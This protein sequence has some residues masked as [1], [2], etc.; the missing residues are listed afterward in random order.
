MSAFFHIVPSATPLVARAIRAL[1]FAFCAALVT[2]C[3]SGGGGSSSGGGGSGGSAAVAPVIVAQPSPQS[4][5]DSQSAS[6]SVTA[7]GSAP[8]TYQWQRSG[9]AIAGATSA[10]Y[11]IPVAQL[12]DNGASF[13]VTVS[14]PAGSAQSAPATLAVTPVAPSL[15]NNVPTTV[16]VVLGQTATFAV[17]ASGSLPLTFQWR[18]GG[19]PIAGANSSGYTTPA[20]T[21]SD[22]G[23]VFD[24]VV[25]NVAGS[26]TSAPFTLNVTPAPTAVAITTQPLSQTIAVGDPVTFTVTASGTGPITYQW[27]RDGTAIAGAQA[28][29]YT[30]PSTA[31]SDSGRQFSV[32]AVNP[33]GFATSTPALLTVTSR[34]SVA[35][36]AGDIGGPGDRDGTGRAA[37]FNAPAGLAVDNAGNLYVGD[38]GN[39]LLRKVAPTGVVTTVAGS[40]GVAGSTDGLGGA[41]RFNFLHAVATDSAGNA[42]V[43][44]SGN[45]IIRKVTPG[46]TVTTLAGTAGVVGSADGTGA[47]ASF[48]FP[49]GIATDAAGNVYVADFANNTIRKITPA[50]VVTTLAGT[51]GGPG[52]ADGTGPAAKFNMPSGLSTDSAGNVY[53]ADSTNQ[54]IRKITPAGVVTTYA[55]VP[56]TRGAA[57]GAAASAS[58]NDPIAL[59]T[60]AAGNVYVADFTNN[61]VRKITPSGTVSTVAG[62]A[63]LSGPIDGVGSG[64]RFAG[65]VAI[66]VDASGVVFVADSSNSAI[67]RIDTNAVVTTFAGSPS[68]TGAIDATGRDARFT[69]PR[70]T[71]TDGAGNVYVAD[72]GNHLIRKVTP[73]GVTTTLAGLAG[74]PG[75][76]DGPAATARF[77]TPI[78][79]AVDASGTVYVADFVNSTIRKITSAGVVSTLAGTAGSRGAVNGTG[80]AAS[81]NGPIALAVDGVGNVYVADSG[82]Q[83]IRRIT[84]AGVVSTYAGIANQAGSADGPAGSATFRGPSGVAVD[85]AGNVYVGDSGNSTIRKID[86]T[87]AVSTIA[88]SVG[89]PG[90]IDGIGTAALLNNPTGVVADT[91]G[92][93]YVV[94]SGNGT[95]RKITAGVVTTVVGVA[96]GRIGILTCALPGRL[97][98]PFQIAI[99]AAGTLFVTGANGVLRL[100]LQ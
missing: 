32:R 98:F 96:D 71:A 72:S 21:F 37:A 6:F 12:S 51:A 31:Q 13:T 65:P 48:S 66:A 15:A 88:G 76:T 45:N 8:L 20:T 80:A 29:S 39:H 49:T 5:K 78:A 14:N 89:N 38:F 52:Y 68:L 41:V 84:P 70:G 73:G 17:T 58:F 62:T 74:T 33:L 9:T 7:V 92:N 44:D 27:L 99:D 24:V 83:L 67:R 79:V 26:I 82:N 90:S 50:G 36:L 22:N 54:V 43:A 35:I 97:A 94:D 69:R 100:I 1:C 53:V 59:A 57:D 25:A 34:P 56:G 4:V 61:T 47:A 63:G 19:V 10:T 11:T 60:D 64:A 16:S 95:V 75:T 42:Y 86:T 91:S 40:A 30:I 81:F 93:V 46:G 23:A 77:N 55:G 87:L 18:R 28:S 3:G 85:A 2:A